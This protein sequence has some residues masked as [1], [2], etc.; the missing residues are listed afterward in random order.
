MPNM[1]KIEITDTYGGDASF[2]W[3]RRYLVSAKSERGA[4]QKMARE[5]GAGWRF[6]GIRYNLSDTCVC[7][8]VDYVDAAEADNFCKYPNVK[9]I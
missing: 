7:M 5:Y 2:S 3:I 9:E 4:V 6:D 8:F 1:Y